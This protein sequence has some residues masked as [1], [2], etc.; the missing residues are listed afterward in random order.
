MTRISADTRQAL[1]DVM[2]DYATGVDERDFA[3]YRSCFTDDAEI[4]GFGSDTV[5]GGD[6]WTDYVKT[7][8]DQFSSTQHMLGPMRVE[9]DGELA[10]CRSDVQAWHELRDPAGSTL[11]LWATYRSTMRLEGGRYRICRHELVSRGRRIE[12]AP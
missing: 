2:L 9:M 8:L 1:Q 5:H 6:A 4:V 11:T 10:Q 3:L 7:A 12:P